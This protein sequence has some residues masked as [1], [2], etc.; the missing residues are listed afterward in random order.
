MK[1]TLLII[2]I[3]KETKLPSYLDL[4]ALVVLIWLQAG[5]EMW[6]RAHTTYTEKQSQQVLLQHKERNSISYNKSI[7]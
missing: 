7:I 5:R 6:A 1:R 3:V 2:P 4:E